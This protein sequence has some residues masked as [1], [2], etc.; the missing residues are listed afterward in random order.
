MN[1]VKW[2]MAAE[3]VWPRTGPAHHNITIGDDSMVRLT[4][5]AHDRWWTL[6]WKPDDQELLIDDPEPILR[7]VAEEIELSE[8]QA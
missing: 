3:V 1:A 5:S 2:L 8:V 4:I 6:A 7:K